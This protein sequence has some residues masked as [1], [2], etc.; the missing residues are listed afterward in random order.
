MHEALA[1]GMLIAPL[2][3][4]HGRADIADFEHMV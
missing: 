4:L 1:E 2:V 3:A